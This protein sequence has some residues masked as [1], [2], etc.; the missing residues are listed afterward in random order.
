MNPKRRITIRDIAREAGT[1]TATVSRVLNDVGYPVSRDLRKKI[2]AAVEKLEYQPNIFGQMLKGGINKMIGVIVP[3]IANPF[4]AQLVSKSEECCIDAG[5]IPVICS[6]HNDP[7]MEQRHLE[8]LERQQ[9]AG[10]LLSTINATA[11]FMKKMS[12][13]SLPCVLFDQP[14]DGYAGSAVSFNFRGG[15]EMATR[16]LLDNGHRDIVF[17]SPCIDR[18]SRKKLYEGYRDAFRG[19]GLRIRSDRVIF[20]SEA[21]EGVMDDYK[22]GTLLA[23]RILEAGYLPDAVVAV[24]DI[25]AIG[26]LNALFEQ[27]VHVPSDMS[28]VGFDDIA[29]SSM[30]TPALTTIRQSVEKTAELAASILFGHIDHPDLIP[31][32]ETIEPELVVRSSVRKIQRKSIS[33]SLHVS[34]RDLSAPESGE[35]DPGVRKKTRKKP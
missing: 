4:Y 8:T 31:V 33:K 11:P 22:C 13:L 5:Y 21:G 28:L 18:G 10:V 34:R 17:A 9:V 19:Y 6:S 14:G 26:I 30:V 15:G 32:R 16:Y 23:A 7:R 3:S 2:L 29:F 24:N 12:A 1:S 35:S 27:G 25:T 20:A